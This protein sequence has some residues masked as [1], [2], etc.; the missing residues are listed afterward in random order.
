[1]IRGKLYDSAKDSIE[2]RKKQ[3]II[4][5]RKEDFFRIVEGKWDKE[6]K[7]PFQDEDSLRF[8][9]ENDQ[10][11]FVGGDD[12]YSIVTPCGRT[13][14]TALCG[15]TR[16]ALTLLH[17]SRRGTYTDITDFNDYGEDIWSRLTET[18]SDILIAY[19]IQKVNGHYP[20]LPI[21]ADYVI[22]NYPHE[23]GTAEAYVRYTNCDRLHLEDGKYYTGKYLHELEYQWYRDIGG[24][25]AKSE[26]LIEKTGKKYHY[27][28][29]EFSVNDLEQKH[30][31]AFSETESSCGDETFRI[32]CYLSEALREPCVKYPINLLLEKR[33]G[34]T[35][36]REVCSVK[37][38]DCSETVR[39]NDIVKLKQQRD[40]MFGVV[41][42]TEIFAERADTMKYALWGFRNFDSTV[43]L[44]NGVRVLEEFVKAVK[45][46]YE[47]GNL[48]VWYRDFIDGKEVMREERAGKNDSV[49]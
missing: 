13:N 26:E 27:P 10:A 36:M 15:D 20:E 46:P 44:Y 38:P 41:L 45:E 3:R 2:E 32:R 18:A 17:N 28:P 47:K 23:G 22:E 11:E 12:W 39:Y 42:D 29:E 48:Y 49:I 40:E 30:S 1:M 4:L 9:R 33:E 14:V 31:T 16:Y 8:I 25:L 21:H 5:C 35:V 43:E 34:K 6:K 37:Y 24:L 19:D 7:R